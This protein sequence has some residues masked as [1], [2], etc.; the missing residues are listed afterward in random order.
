MHLLRGETRG[1]QGENRRP[2]S[3]RDWLARMLALGLTGPALVKASSTYGN[4]EQT[5]WSMP[6]LFP[7][8]VARVEHSASIVNGTYQREPIQ[9]MMRRGMQELTGAPD[10]V[11]AWRM[12]FEPGDVVGIKLNPVSRPYVISSPEVVH[13]IIAGLEAAGVSRKNIIAYDRYKREFFDAGFDKW[14]PDGVRTAWAADYVDN[15][16]QRIEGYDPDHFMDMQ[17]TLPGFDLS[18]ERARR[19]Y[20]ATFIT[21]DVNKMVNLCLLKHHA[22]A[23][24]TFALK[25]MSHGLV[26][27]VN[28]SHSSPMLNACG[29]FIPTV[30][31][32]PIIRSK[33]ILH[34]GDAVQGLAHGGPGL[35]PAKRKYIW[36]HKAMLFSTDPVAMDTIGWEELDAQRVKMGMKPLAEA[37]IHEEHGEFVR[38]QPEHVTIA[39][40]LGLGEG[41]RKKIDLRR[42]TLG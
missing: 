1:F 24:I 29:T 10:W 26:N 13:E 25:N 37:T 20:A 31:A 21:R 9:H 41:D 28:R 39:G 14:L 17:L 23:G 36:E 11:S 32:M 4:A 16:Q 2:E 22:S 8:R 18:N 6:G 5:K 3:R 35:S 12:F 15:V 42:I 30:V 27:N 19:S 40:A 33:C 7:G 34:I 38:M